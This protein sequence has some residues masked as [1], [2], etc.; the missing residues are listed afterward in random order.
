[1]EPQIVAQTDAYFADLLKTN[2]PIR[3]LIDS[4]YTFM[5]EGIADIFYGRK[6]VKGDSLRKV[7]TK[8]RTSRRNPDS[9]RRVMTATANGVDTHRPLFAACGC[10]KTSLAHRLRHRP[11]DIEPLSPDLR[12]AKTIREQLASP[13]QAGSLQTVATARSIRLGFAFENFDPHRPLARQVSASRHHRRIDHD[14]R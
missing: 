5:N 8:D 14:G 3:L 1:M 11:P 7:A 13:P 6:D 2:G 9:T 12:N 10:S 4:D